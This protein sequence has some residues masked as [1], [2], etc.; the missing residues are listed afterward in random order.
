MAI[1]F[2]RIDLSGQSESFL[3]QE[4]KYA[5]NK[6]WEARE[7]IKKIHEWMVHSQDGV[8]YSQLETRFGL[9]TDSGSSVFTL[10]DGSLQAMD[11][12][13]SGYINDLLGRV[14]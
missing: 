10:V 3:A 8:D 13:S 4:L 1:D 14:G 9:P 12:T 7:G 6:L 2:I 11:G 5:I